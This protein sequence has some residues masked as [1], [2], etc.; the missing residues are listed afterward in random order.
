MPLLIQQWSQK[1]TKSKLKANKLCVVAFGMSKWLRNCHILVEKNGYGNRNDQ[2]TTGMKSSLFWSKCVCVCTCVSAHTHL[3]SG[4]HSPP[5]QG[6]PQCVAIGCGRHPEPQSWAQGGSAGTLTLLWKWPC[7]SPGPAVAPSHT[8]PGKAWHHQSMKL[9][10]G[11]SGGVVQTAS[12]TKTSK[13]MGQFH[14]QTNPFSSKINSNS[15]SEMWHSPRFNLIS[16]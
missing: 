14:G 8:E 10:A 7:L 12:P 2:K 4:S 6:G 9:D 11:W 13:I 15:I 5:L 16:F 1:V 3:L